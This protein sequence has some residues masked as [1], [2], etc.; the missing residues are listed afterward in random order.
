M[1]RPHLPRNALM[2][3]QRLEGGRAATEAASTYAFRALNR[4]VAGRPP[5]EPTRFANGVSAAL[6]LDHLVERQ[7]PARD[8]VDP[9]VGQAGVAVLVDR[10]G[11][12]DAVAILRSEDRINDG[13]LREV[14]PTLACTLDRVKHQGHRLV[15]VDG[16]RVRRCD[17]VL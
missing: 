9:V 17:V 10:V 13:L 7:L 16:V 4:R 5:W 11:A 3:V 8:L 6:R 12:E 15:A 1:I 14:A 2:A